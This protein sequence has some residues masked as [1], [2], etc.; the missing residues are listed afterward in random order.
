[1]KCFPKKVISANVLS[2]ADSISCKYRLILNL[3]KNPKSVFSW[4]II[5]FNE[6]SPQIFKM[7]TPTVEMN[8]EIFTISPN[9]TNFDLKSIIFHEKKLI[10]FY[11]FL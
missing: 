7:L 9:L 8:G 6:M 1:M 2:A 11:I 4:K 3:Q 5:D 10:P